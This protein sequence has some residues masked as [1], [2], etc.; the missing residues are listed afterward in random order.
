MVAQ[1]ID[2]WPLLTIN[3]HLLIFLRVVSAIESC[4]FFL[5]VTTLYKPEPFPKVKTSYFK[6]IS[7]GSCGWLREENI[8]HWM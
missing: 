4:K 7:A 3:A 2:L 8:K 1:A 5:V 6:L